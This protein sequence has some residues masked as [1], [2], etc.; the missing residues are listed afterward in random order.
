[1]IWLLPAGAVVV[2][3]LAFWLFRSIRIQHEPGREKFQDEGA[4]Q[5]YD[6]TSGWIPF[7]FERWLMKRALSRIGPNG[8]LLDIGCGPGHLAAHLSRKF[9]NLECTGLDLN[10]A[11]LGIAKRRFRGTPRLG[12]VKGDVE[13][14]PFGDGC[15]NMVVSSLSLH[16]WS[17]PEG[18]LKEMRRVLA[19][20]GRLVLFDLRRDCPRWMYL[21][22]LTG[23]KLFL[24]RNIRRTN[25]AVGSI[26]AS[27]TPDEVSG[28]MVEAGF[29]RYQVRRAF[30]W[31]LV[32]AAC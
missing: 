13:S 22:F 10:D 1:M 14:L 4:S 21:V 8:K 17:N 24:P 16:H 15:V 31:V 26:W 5:D 32:T 9:P 2:A 7:R 20:G 23:Q 27:Y 25:G 3:A 6:A 11:M 28:M 29:Q 19:E 12:F 18:G 30:G